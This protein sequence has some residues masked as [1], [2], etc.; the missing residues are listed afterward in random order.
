MDLQ[1]TEDS[2]YTRLDDKDEKEDSEIEI[3]YK[4]ILALAIPASLST[5]LFFS[6]EVINLVFI[7]YLNNPA[8]VAAIGLGNMTI[9]FTCLSIIQGLNSALQSLISQA[10]GAG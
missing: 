5:I 4:G 2:N 8:M 6:I 1:E 7:G 3:G 10:S 9:N